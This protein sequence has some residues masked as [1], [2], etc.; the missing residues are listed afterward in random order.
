MLYIPFSGVVS[1]WY[2][3][4]GVNN[5]NFKHL[6]KNNENISFIVGGFEGNLFFLILYF[7]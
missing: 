1:R 6:M 3:L 4:E 7:F 5:E 2:G